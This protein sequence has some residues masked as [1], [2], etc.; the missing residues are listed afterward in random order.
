MPRAYIPFEVRR[1]VIERARERCEYCQSRADFT[2]ETFAIEH[3]IPLSRDGTD[4]IANLALACSGCNSRKYN[5]TKAHD[6][7]SN[8]MVSLF[9]PR[10]QLW[11]EHFGWDRTYKQMIGLTDIGRATIHALQMNRQS[12]QNIRKAMLLLG[13]HPP[14]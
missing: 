9:N 8:R 12:V 13:I 1:A 4:N 2:T 7:M 14:D 10:T 6:L 11:S 3:V 5:K